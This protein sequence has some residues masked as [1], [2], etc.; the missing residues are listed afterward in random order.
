MYE[1]YCLSGNEI[2]LL[3]IIEIID[4]LS[5]F[6]DCL[7][8]L[9]SCSANAHNEVQCPTHRKFLPISKQIYELFSTETIQDLADEIKDSN[10]KIAA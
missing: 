3:N 10:G 8:G 6:D 2:T 9:S 1:E 7:I 5:L 4:G